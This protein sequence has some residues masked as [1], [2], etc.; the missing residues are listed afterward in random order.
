MEVN[1]HLYVDEICSLAAGRLS[2]IRMWQLSFEDKLNLC[3]S[4]NLEPHTYCYQRLTVT[5]LLQTSP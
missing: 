1:I 4:T 3:C 5:W 2:S